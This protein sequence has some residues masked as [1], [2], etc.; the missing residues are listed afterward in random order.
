MLFNY[1]SIAI[2]ILSQI[3]QT[4]TLLEDA[5]LFFTDLSSKYGHPAEKYDVTTE[6]GYILTLYRLPGKSKLPVL[7]MHGLF[8]TADSWILRGNTSLPITLANSGYDVWI[9]NCRG[10]TYSRKHI[11]ISPNSRKFWNFTFHELAIY[12]LR[13]VIDKVLK[14]TG[15][16]KLN[17]IG[18]SL[19]NTIFYVLGSTVPEY[20][21]KL[22]LL[23]ALSPI[24]YLHNVPSPVKNI[25]DLAPFFKELRKQNYVDK[26]FGPGLIKQLLEKICAN[27]V[28]GYIICVETLLFPLTGFNREE[29]G[30]DFLPILISHFPSSS[31][32][33]NLLHLAQVYNRRKFAKYDYGFSKNF[34]LYNSTKPPLYDLGKVKMRIALISAK[35]DRLSTLKDVEILRGRLTNIVSDLVMPLD[36]FNHVDYIWGERTNLYLH[37]Y[38]LSEL[39]MYS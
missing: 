4:L 2:I 8:S 37:P 10:N 17:A 38:I 14:E 32:L 35:N 22:N 7:L 23:I 20:N 13:A 11:H 1:S 28:Y 36:K 26:V 21:E 9:G 30:P 24:C 12:D 34:L 39:K 31:S 29:L 5:K 6:D 18:H 15:A 33:K 19:G 25:L 3:I 16:K 27:P